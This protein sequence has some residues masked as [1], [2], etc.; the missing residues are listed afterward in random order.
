MKIT[1]RNGVREENMNEN[2]IKAL[3]EAL[4]YVLERLPSEAGLYE[5]DITKE[6]HEKKIREIL[7][8]RR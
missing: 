6:H 4:L 2:E 7:V 8:L 3:L 1:A 5:R